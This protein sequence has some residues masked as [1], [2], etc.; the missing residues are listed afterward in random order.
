MLARIY[1]RARPL[2]GEGLD[3]HPEPREGS[4]P[5]ESSPHCQEGFLFIRPS[6]HPP[7]GGTARSPAALAARS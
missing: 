2:G 5:I 3:G 1:V 4:R 7:E 6:L